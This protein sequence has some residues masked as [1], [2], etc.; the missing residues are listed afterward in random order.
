MN[1]IILAAGMGSRLRPITDDRPKCLVTLAG[2]TLLLRQIDAWRNCGVNDIA[3]VTG[4]QAE[5]IVPNGFRC[6]RNE[7]YER[8]N[9]VASLFCAEDAM[10]DDRD[11][12]ISYGDVVFEQRIGHALLES[13]HPVSVAVDTGWRSLWELR[14]EDPLQDAETLKLTPDGHI[15]ELGLKPASYDDIEGQYMGLIKVQRQWVAKFRQA[16]HDLR[17]SAPQGGTSVDNMYMTAFLQHLIDSGWKVGA[18]PVQH[19]WLELDSL[20]ELNRYEQLWESGG[21]AR[22]CNLDEAAG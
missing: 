12:V 16:Y 1:L 14:M 4:Y 20:A 19:G 15:R 17:R 13:L 10:R 9:M 21:L 8:T 2:R 5:R 7:N 18:V 22:F 3:V 6:F 11:L